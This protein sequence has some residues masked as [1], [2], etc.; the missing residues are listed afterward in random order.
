MTGRGRPRKFDEEEVLRAAVEVFW[1][2]G[3]DE[4]ALESVI[5]SSGISR[6]S[7][8]NVFGSKRDLFFTAVRRYA[9]DSEAEWERLFAAQPTP[10]AGLRAFLDRWTSCPVE[11]EGRGCLMVGSI[12]AVARRDPEF[13]AFADEHVGRQRERLVAA[14][15]AAVEAGELRPSVDPSDLGTQLLATVL[16]MATFAHLDGM[17]AAVAGAARSARA[18][19]DAFACDR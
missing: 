5:E 11:L 10:L 14:V 7:L 2:H 16:G 4:A 6:Q 19:L 9:E 1:E 17:S 12:N 8:Y 13:A 18:T 3:F 15:R